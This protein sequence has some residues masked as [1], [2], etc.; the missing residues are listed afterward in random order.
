MPVMPASR[1]WLEKIVAAGWQIILITDR[2]WYPE[3]RDDTW[4]WLQS[5]KIPFHSV[6]FIKNARKA[7]R[8][9]QLGIRTFVEDHLSNANSLAEV[10]DRVFLLD[11]SY[12]QGITAKRVIRIS[13]LQETLTIL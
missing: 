11:R 6:E 7:K 13:N 9:R 12:N 3:I 10:C 2:F 1:E 8:A 4:D 5:H